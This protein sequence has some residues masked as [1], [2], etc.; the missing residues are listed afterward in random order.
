MSSLASICIAKGYIVTGSDLRPNNLTDNLIKNGAIIFKGHKESNVKKD[1]DLIVKSAC[2]KDN[3]PEIIKGKNYNIPIIYRSELLQQI[4]KEFSFSVAIT[5]T[6]GKTTT[7]S[8]CSHI[9]H[10]SNKKPTIIVGG[11]VLSLESNVVYDKND[12]VVAEIDESDGFF[13][14]IQSKVGVITNIE[15]EHMETYKTFDNLLNSNKKFLNNISKQG[16]LIFNGEDKNIKK[17]IDTVNI[18]KISFGI[19]G[20]FD[21]T[22]KNYYYNKFIEFDLIIKNKIYGQIKSILIGR[23]NIMNILASIAIGF[24]YGLNF[25]QIRETI[26]SFKGVKRR[27]EKIG[28]IFDIEIIEDYAHHPTEIKCVLNAAK[29]YTLGRTIAIFQPHRYSR[30]KDLINDFATCFFDAD[31]LILTDIYSADEEKKDNIEVNDLYNIINKNKFEMIKTIKKEK[32]IDVVSNI[33]KSKDL[34]LILGAGDIRD[35]SKPLLNKIK[36]KYS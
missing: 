15:K 13:S 19:N 22:C 26:K 3:N 6:H 23:H 2:I 14:D 20:N 29:N 33:V 8:I 32:I 5:G 35:I 21:I 31:I 11:E 36:E 4:I 18:K 10:F 28:T 27:F 34:I 9:F 24:E 16:C 7:S 30:T 12:I 25:N 1:I 17:I